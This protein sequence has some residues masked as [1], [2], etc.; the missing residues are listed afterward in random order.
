MT[1]REQALERALRNCRDACMVPAYVLDAEAALALPAE[2]CAECGLLQTQVNALE[3]Q[4]DR[5]Q[6]IVDGCPDNY[7]GPAGY[8]WFKEQVLPAKTKE[9]GK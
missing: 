8:L 9:K 3:I 6:A 2:P 7:G 5:L 1:T 4:R